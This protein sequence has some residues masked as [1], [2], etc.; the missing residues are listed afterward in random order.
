MATIAPTVE[1]SIA[2]R[3]FSHISAL[4]L[5]TLGI[6]LKYERYVR[7]LILSQTS[8]AD[9]KRLESCFIGKIKFQQTFFVL[10]QLSEDKLKLYSSQYVSL[11]FL[12]IFPVTF[13]RFPSKRIRS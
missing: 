12:Q 3:A 6:R 7:L 10:L 13:E 5:L 9:N 11:K 2:R 8:Q 1:K 4:I